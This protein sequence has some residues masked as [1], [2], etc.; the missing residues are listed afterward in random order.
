MK[1]LWWRILL[2]VVVA[3]SLGATLV[4]AFAEEPLHFRDPYTGELTDEEISTIHDDLTY[5]LGLAETGTVP[6]AYRQR[7]A[8]RIRAVVPGSVSRDPQQW[9]TYCI[10][11]L[12]VAPRPDSLAAD[13]IWEDVQANLDYRI[14]GQSPEGT[15]DP[16]WNWGGTYPEAWAQAREEWRGHLTL[17]TLTA[18]Q[19]YERLEL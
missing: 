13:L 15:W 8:A 3:L 17:E 16:V 9:A 14:A 2:A 1:R 18:L 12:K 7:L 5:A 10:Q 19:A 4:L 6:L 11:P